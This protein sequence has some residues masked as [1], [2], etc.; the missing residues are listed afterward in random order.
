[1]LF[2]P[3][4][5]HMNADLVPHD[6]YIRIQLQFLE[7]PGLKL[8][9]DQLGRL[10]GLTSEMSEAALAALIGKGFLRRSS[11]GRFLR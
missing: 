8:T 4:G 11:D 10:C 2:W 3:K 6:I 9:I 7:M 5:D 1:M